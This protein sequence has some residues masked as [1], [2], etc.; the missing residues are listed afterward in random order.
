[1]F[2]KGFKIGDLVSFSRLPLKESPNKKRLRRKRI[3]LSP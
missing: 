3:L 2:K 1:V